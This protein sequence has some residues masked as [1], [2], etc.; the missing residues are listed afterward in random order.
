MSYLATSNCTYIKT[1]ET[2]ILHNLLDLYKVNISGL[3]ANLIITDINNGAFATNYNIYSNDMLVDNIDQK[4]YDMRNLPYGEHNIYAVAEGV[5]FNNSPKSNLFHTNIFS[6]SENLVNLNLDFFEKAVLYQTISVTLSANEGYYLPREISVTVGGESA[7]YVYNCY[8]GEVIISNVT[9]DVEIIAKASTSPT[10]PK[11]EVVV[12]NNDVSW[13]KVE[14]ATSYKVYVDREVFLE[15]QDLTISL[16]DRLQEEK[17]YVINVTAISV[18]FNE[19]PFSEDIILS[20]LN[21]YPVYGVK[22]L[23]NNGRTELERTYDAVGLNYYF[24]T[25]QGQIISDFDNVF[26]FSEIKEV[27]MDG[28]AMV[29]IPQMYFN[30]EYNLNGVLSAVAVSRYPRREGKWFKSNE[31]YVGKYLSSLYNGKLVSVTNAIINKEKSIIELENIAKQSGSNYNILNFKHHCIIRLLMYIEYATKNFNS[32]ILKDASIID[33]GTTDS[34]ITNS[35]YNLELANFKYRYIEDFIGGNHIYMGGI[36]TVLGEVMTN[37]Y[38]TEYV[39]MGVKYNSVTNNVYSYLWQDD[40]PF[41][42]LPYEITGNN[43]NGAYSLIFARGDLEFVYGS[44]GVLRNGRGLLPFRAFDKIN[45]E[46]CSSRLVW[47]DNNDN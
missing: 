28:N 29:K 8:T 44:G 27:V 5:N 26:P 43:S 46:A 6:C 9:G 4:E 15:T 39:S 31:F 12:K 18:G 30:V 36:K 2:K 35:G 45:Y 33:T 20:Y 24:N 23:E 10:L 1:K 34:V 38:S 7:E 16:N 47:E 40:F 3:G 41:L 11:V 19:S 14:N 17:D 21:E 25:S 37:I 32:F 13:T 42:L 22:G